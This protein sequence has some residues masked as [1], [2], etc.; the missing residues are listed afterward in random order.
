MNIER[1]SME[2]RKFKIIAINDWYEDRHMEDGD[3]CHM[4][5][6]DLMRA[7]LSEYEE[8]IEG[9]KWPG[10]PFECMAEDEDEAVQ[11]YN[12]AHCDYDYFKATEAEFEDLHDFSP[13]TLKQVMETCDDDTLFRIVD[14]TEDEKVVLNS[15]YKDDVKSIL[16]ILYPL[17]DREVSEMRVGMSED[18]LSPKDTMP[19]VWVSL[20]ARG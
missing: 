10:L 20:L 7:R 12:D 4:S 5:E 19:T 14:E 13:V 3:A 16:E 17:L 8:K 2:K 11:K 15:D 9:G 6:G 18:P 1:S